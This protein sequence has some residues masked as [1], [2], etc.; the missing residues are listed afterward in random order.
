MK[1]K[2]SVCRVA[3]ITGA[4]EGIGKAAAKKFSREGYK[5][6]CLGR[7]KENTEATV[8]ALEQLGGVA[9]TLVADITDYPQMENAVEM[10]ESKWGRL[11]VLFAN[12][13]VN[14][15][16]AGIEELSPEEFNQTV[17]I[18]LN[19]TFHSV[20]ASVRLLKK[21]GGSIVVTS[22]VNGNRIFTNTGATA[23]S[24]SKAAQV[25][26]VK[27]LALE[28]APQK[29]RVNAICPGAI[30]T[31]ISDNTQVRHTEDV[32][33]PVE[34]P[35]GQIPLTGGDP[36]SPAQCA[37]L[38]YFLGSDLSSHVSGSAIYVDGAQS[39]LQG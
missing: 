34:F 14:G 28:L 24:C 37:E 31:Q 8:Q 9:L 38:V 33:I 32:Q 6:A 22:S 35:E 15:V 26:M 29:I 5:V 21:F 16:W 17:Q 1:R 25:A 18:N 36:G 3:L 27:M 2:S 39:L 30:E 12:A 20:K 11:D 23:Y 10:I 4:G 13:G 19:G 7:H